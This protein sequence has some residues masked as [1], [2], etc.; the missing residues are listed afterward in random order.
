MPWG[1]GCLGSATIGFATS[2]PARACVSRA[3]RMLGWT[4]LYACLRVPVQS[5]VGRS[6]C[7]A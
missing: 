4:R 1:A 6:T 5:H 3:L 7:L 2:V